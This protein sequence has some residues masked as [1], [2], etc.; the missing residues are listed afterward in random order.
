VIIAPNGA[1]FARVGAI[2]P[3]LIDD[4]MASR[5]RAKARGDRH[6]DQA[7]KIMMNAFFG[8]LGASACRFF[9]PDVA[10]AITGFGQQTL[11]WTKELL[12]AEGVRVLYGDTDSVFVEL[13]DTRTEEATAAAAALRERVEAG[14]AAR[15]RERYRVEPRLVL[16]L[17]YVLERFFMPR[18]RSGQG[19]SKKRYAGWR[20]GRLHVVGLESVRRDWPRLARRLQEGMLERV[21]TDRDPVAFVREVA[22][23]LRAGALDGELIYVKR[24]RKGGTERYVAST[25]PHVQA[26]RKAGGASGGV[27]R[28]VMTAGGPEPAPPGRPLPEGIDREHYVEKVL[29]PIADA[30][31][32]ELGTSFAEALGEPRQLTLL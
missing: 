13:G 15:I 4:F 25:P 7:I 3:R 21:F 18:V 32:L 19:G 27:V 22:E 14:I 6:A 31:L 10:N 29:R 12:E 26:A 20:A 5:E 23:Q 9:D 8:V 28:Y 2:L 17:E 24:I 1:R 16:E 30:I 11:A